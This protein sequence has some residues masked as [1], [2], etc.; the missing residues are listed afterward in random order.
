MIT[1]RAWYLGAAGA[2]AVALVTWWFF[3][4]V[5]FPILLTYDNAVTAAFA[6]AAIQVL[7]SGEDAQPNSGVNRG[8]SPFSNPPPLCTAEQLP[9]TANTGACLPVRVVVSDECRNQ[10]F[11]AEI[12]VHPSVRADPRR[13]VALLRALQNPCV[14]LPT[15]NS[16]PVRFGMILHPVVARRVLR[17]GGVGEVHGRPELKSQRNPI[18]ISF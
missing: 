5:R 8:R 18:R 16:G 14:A 2:A 1:Q 11:C 13:L 3:P 9:T 7:I 12:E 15:R 4:Y 6:D 10:H 17:C